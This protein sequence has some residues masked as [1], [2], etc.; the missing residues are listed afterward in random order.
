M[1][2]FARWTLQVREGEVHGISILDDEEPNWIKI[3]HEF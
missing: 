3:P 1:E 2:A